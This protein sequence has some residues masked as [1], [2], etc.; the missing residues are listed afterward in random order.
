M[1]KKRSPVGG[2][3]G[4]AA[5]INERDT[6][7]FASDRVEVRHGQGL[8]H[9]VHRDVAIFVTRRYPNAAGAAGCSPVAFSNLNA[10]N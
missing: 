10:R 8:R 4:L 2:L 9:A 1:V 3:R 6:F 5:P 7:P